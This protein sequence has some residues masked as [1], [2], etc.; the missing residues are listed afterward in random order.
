MRL[1]YMTATRWAEVVLQERR[2]KLSRFSEAND[3]FE[4][5]L[6]DNRD[7][8]VRRYADLIYSYFEANVGFICFGASWESPV[9]WAHYADKHSG[10]ALG[11]DVPDVL[12]TRII[13]TNEKVKVPIGQ[14]LPQH[15]LSQELLT[16][17][18]IT[19]ATDWAYEREYRIESKLQHKDPG[20]GLFYA[21]FGP[22]LQ[23]AEVVIGCRCSWTLEEVC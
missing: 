3:P 12:A 1:Y 18:R 5:R 7:P 22:Q 19:K 16:K 23:L 11:F 6:F 17:V 10:V 2:M 9:M 21:D 14:H 13:Y 4:L 15:G 8:E 20:T